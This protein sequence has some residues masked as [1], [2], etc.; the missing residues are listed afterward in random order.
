MSANL[1]VETVIKW[2]AYPWQDTSAS[3]FPFEHLFSNS[4]AFAKVCSPNSMAISRY[5]PGKGSTVRYVEERLSKLSFFCWRTS[6]SLSKLMTTLLFPESSADSSERLGR[7]GLSDQSLLAAQDPKLH[8]LSL[9]FYLFT[10]FGLFS[11]ECIFQGCFGDGE[12][13]NG[14]SHPDPII[15]MECFYTS[16]AAKPV[17]IC[18]RGTLFRKNQH[19]QSSPLIM[20]YLYLGAWKRVNCLPIFSA[21]I[22]RLFPFNVIL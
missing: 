6:Q 20:V 15:D 8:L 14:L 10:F 2:I 11:S 16:L 17:W 5:C 19:R 1:N 3:I 4:L 18:V 21:R 9:Q 12:R 7:E 13:S 22:W